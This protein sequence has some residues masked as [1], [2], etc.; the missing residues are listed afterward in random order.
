MAVCFERLQELTRNDLNIFL[1]NEFQVPVNAAEIYFQLFYVD[2][3]MGSP[4]I[5][6]PLAGGKKFEPV[7]PSIGEY[8][9]SIKIPA[10]S[11]LG[12]H[13]IRWY[14][15]RGF[16]TEFQTVVQEFCIG[17][18]S[19]GTGTAGSIYSPCEQ[20][21]INRFRILVRDNNPDR[22]YNFAPPEQESEIGKFNRVFGYLFEDYEIVTFLQTA[23]EYWN[24]F[25]PETEYISNLNILCQQKPTWKPYILWGAVA[26]AMFALSVNWVRNEFDYS[27][28]GV[29]L[30]MERSSKYESMKS[31]AEQTFDKQ[32]ETKMQTVKVIRGLKQPRF[33]VG[34]RSAFGP[35][36]ASGV[37]S[38]RAFV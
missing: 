31:S 22:N 9:A 12:T 7:N 16:D 10:A 24:G 37:L 3:S 2:E 15:R 19:A 26:H 35:N 8:Y 23:L 11:G 18:N 33:G 17:Q 29:S 34:I 4:G 36:V 21:L 14:F 13:R 25:P 30:S 1:Q 28:G 5:E 32:L 27:I 6:V 38:P 20:D